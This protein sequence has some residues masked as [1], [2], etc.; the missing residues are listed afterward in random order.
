M[1]GLLIIGAAIVYVGFFGFLVT[2]FRN[3]WIRCALILTS[4]LIPFWEFPIGYAMYLSNCNK[5]A[6]IEIISK[7][8]PTTSIFF[9]E[10]G[11]ST[12]QEARKHGIMTVE[13]GKPGKVLRVTANESG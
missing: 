7:I 9:G 4:I 12:P 3:I 1:A 5:D 2:K 8:P 11:G 6:G 10:F 13:Y